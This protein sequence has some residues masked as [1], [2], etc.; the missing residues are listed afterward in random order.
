MHTR[1]DPNQRIC[2]GA[3]IDFAYIKAAAGGDFVDEQF[4]A[5]WSGASAAGLC[6]GAYHFFT[7]C[8]PG[9]AQANNFRRT[10]PAAPGARS[11]VDLEF[12]WNCSG[13]PSRD[14]FL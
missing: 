8:R 10:V 6:R 12:D 2:E 5:N 14:P 3:G 11:V 4:P 9:A 7:L 13:R 1:V